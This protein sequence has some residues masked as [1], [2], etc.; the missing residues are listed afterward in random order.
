MLGAISEGGAAPKPKLTDWQRREACRI[1]LRNL[2]E[3]GQEEAALD[4]LDEKPQAAK[5]ADGAGRLPLHI[6]VSRVPELAEAVSV[7]VELHPAACL[8]P[9]PQS[10]GELPLHVALAKGHSDLCAPRLAAAAA[11]TFFLVS[12]RR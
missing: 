2:L 4:L 10:K 8:Q 5:E 6:A 9:D 7:L 3:G 1:R 11:A 12:R